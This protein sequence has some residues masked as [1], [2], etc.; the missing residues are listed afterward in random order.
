MRSPVRAA[1]ASDAIHQYPP[2]TSQSSVD[3][4]ITNMITRAIAYFSATER[5]H[6][7]DNGF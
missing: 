2:K 1:T 5:L 7:D 3:K 6:Y 4:H